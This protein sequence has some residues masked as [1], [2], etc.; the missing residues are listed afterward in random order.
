MHFSGRSLRRFHRD[1][2][3]NVSLFNLIYLFETENARAYITKNRIIS[4]L[5]L[6][7]LKRSEKNLFNPNPYL[8]LMKFITFQRTN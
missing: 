6:S 2:I 3:N 4:I 1:M 7:C 5:V 8:K